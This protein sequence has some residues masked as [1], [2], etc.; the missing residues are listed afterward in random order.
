MKISR[1]NRHNA[2]VFGGFGVFLAGLGVMYWPLSLVALGL[3]A[4]AIG[5][6]ASLRE[7]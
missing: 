2:L 7:R 5:V 4:A 1:D 6:Y 3:A